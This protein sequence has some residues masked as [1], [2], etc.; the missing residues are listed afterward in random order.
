[1]LVLYNLLQL[2]LYNF[3]HTSL[4]FS[5]LASD[6]FKLSKLHFEFFSFLNVEYLNSKRSISSFFAYLYVYSKVKGLIKSS[7]STQPTY[8]PSI[9]FNPSVLAEPG[10]NE[11]FFLWITTILESIFA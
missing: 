9:W 10:L 11:V 3:G 7:A 1:M 4:I 5:I 6:K 2:L 8:S